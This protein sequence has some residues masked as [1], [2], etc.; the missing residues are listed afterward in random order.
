MA[1]SR[2]LVGFLLVACFGSSAA[3][4]Q[5]LY[6]ADIVGRLYDLE[7]LARPPVPGERCGNFS[8]WD[9]GAKY[10]AQTGTYENWHANHDGGG[11]V[12]REGEGIVAAAKNP[13]TFTVRKH[14][15][16]SG[17]A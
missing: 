4:E 1:R 11:S 15:H 13:G 9:R 12:R 6:Y 2:I 17:G 5:K 14:A 3:A 7:R 16:A 10:I 8:S